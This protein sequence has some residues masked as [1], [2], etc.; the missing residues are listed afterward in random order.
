MSARMV[1]SRPF[2]SSRASTATGKV[3]VIPWLP[4]PELLIT[5]T[6]APSIRAS[7]AAVV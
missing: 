2:P 3:A 4:L 1:S 6:G 7:H 5:D